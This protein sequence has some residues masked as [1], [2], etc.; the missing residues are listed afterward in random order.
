MMNDM[1]AVATAVTE[2]DIQLRQNLTS[3]KML[4]EN[5]FI[6]HQLDKRTESGTFVLSDH[7]RAMV[8][9]M[10]SS[11]ITWK[12]VENMTDLETG[13]IIPLDDL[14]H[15]YD[16]DY[17]L[18]CDP[19]P[20]LSAEIKGLRLASQYTENQMK[21]LITVNI[22]KLKAIEKEYGSI[23][24]LYKKYIIDGDISCLVWKLSAADSKMKYAQMGEALVAEYLKNVGY[25]TSKPDRHIRRILGS[26]HLACSDSKI[27]PIFE[28]F[29]IV[30][31]IAK[32][33]GKPTA[34]V[35]YILWSYCASGYGEICTQKNPKCDLCKAKELCALHSK[36]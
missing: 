25:N 36:R 33:S 2:M 31:D 7:I 17:V 23:D 24:T 15:E 14:F 11:G 5:T 35:D 21:A 13:R 32:E 4:W 10:L 6:K 27:V 1:K 29:D 22:P 19:P 8:Y 9:S 12:R 18:G 3:P 20:E 28:A 34:E 16:P 26:N 30:A